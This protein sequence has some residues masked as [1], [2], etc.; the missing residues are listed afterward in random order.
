MSWRRD[1][2]S[3]AALAQ[4]VFHFLIAAGRHAG[5]PVLGHRHERLAGHAS[6]RARSRGS[7]CRCARRPASDVG[8]LLQPGVIDRAVHRHVLV[9]SSAA[10]GGRP[11]RLI[12]ASPK[13]TSL[14][15]PLAA[16][17]RML[18]GLMSRWVRPAHVRVSQALR[19]TPP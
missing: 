13:S 18:V 2:E 3:R 10:G 5:L 12:S 11:S 14:A 7:R 16:A 9:P 1:A 6:R 4:R 17:I 15:C 19:R 8:R